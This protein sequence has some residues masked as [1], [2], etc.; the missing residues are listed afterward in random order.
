LGQ[1]G[2]KTDEFMAVSPKNFI[3][4]YSAGHRLGQITNVIKGEARYPDHES[5]KLKL[6]STKARRWGAYMPMVPGFMCKKCVVL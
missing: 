3:F 1:C 5:D 6:V 2:L 4:L